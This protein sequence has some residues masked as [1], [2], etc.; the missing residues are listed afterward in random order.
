MNKKSLALTN[1]LVGLIGG[2]ILIFGFYFIGLGA[3]N[4]LSNLNTSASSSTTIAL[5]L[6]VL[7]LVILGLGI[8]GAVAFK[9][10]TEVT[11]APSVLMI[12]GGGVALIPFLG[13]VGGIISIVGGSLYLAKLKNFDVAIQ[14]PSSDETNAN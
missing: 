11:T 8:F 13:W 10:R 6:N 9:D 7:K 5:I 12:V 4:D 1:G 2:I 3:A 14:N